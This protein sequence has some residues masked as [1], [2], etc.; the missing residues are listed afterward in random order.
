MNI[1][2]VVEPFAAGIATFVKSLTETLSNDRHIVIHGERKPVMSAEDVKRSFPIHNVQFIRWRYA[3]REIDPF[4]DL[5]AVGELFSIIQKLKKEDAVD[6]VHLHSSKSGFL[7]RAACRL[8]GITNIVYTPNGASFLAGKSKV[9]KFLYQQLEKMADGL[10]G[11]VVCC[12]ESEFQEYKRIGIDACYVNNGVTL[13]TPHAIQ[14]KKDSRF[15]IVTTG[16]IVDQKNPSLFNS[17][18]S[19]FEHYSNIEFIW[20]G[21][22]E[23]K[24][25]ELLKASNINITGWL[26]AADV[27]D[28]VANADVYISTSLYEGLSFG[29]LEALELQKPVLLT[30]CIGNQD[31]I[32]G[33]ANG[34]YFNNVS[35]A[36]N[37]ILHY[38][39]N[40]S[41]LKVMGGF[42]RELCSEQFDQ[43]RNFT[44][45]RNIYAKN[46]KRSAFYKV[47]G[48]KAKIENV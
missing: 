43:N 30:D 26:P 39:T 45:Y 19:Y 27:K 18:A 12:S 41:M 44:T 6:A 25:K 15:R 35:E 24:D 37:K 8:A 47:P 34:D 21:D 22:G 46:I 48:I 23:T 3:Q 16:R 36:I 5:F 4:K 31:I 1:V 17:I 14:P 9:S 32:R 28:I 20:V 10:G 38:H 2:H 33:G 11:Q 40:R 29:V 42:S 7:G 13:K